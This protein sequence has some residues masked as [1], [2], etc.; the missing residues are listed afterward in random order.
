MIVKNE[1]AFLEKCLESVKNYIDEII[2]VDTGSTDKTVEIAS[3]YT[4]KVY[5][6]PWE[7]NFS[8]ARNQALSYATCDWIFQIDGDEELIEGSGEKLLKAVLESGSGRCISGQH[9]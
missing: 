8:K 3:R 6:H 7:G 5:F 4:D 2:I 1:E 9:H